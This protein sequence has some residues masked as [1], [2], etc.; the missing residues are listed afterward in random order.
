MFLRNERAEDLVK[1]SSR[2][3]IA[4]NFTVQTSE[5]HVQLNQIKN[6]HEGV[7]FS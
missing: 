7:V 6:N 1:K 5:L 4:H 2:R 3:L